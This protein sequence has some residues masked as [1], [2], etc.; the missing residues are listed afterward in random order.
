MP[1]GLLEVFVKVNPVWDGVKLRVRTSLQ[2]EVDAIDSIRVCIKHCMRWCDFS[3]TRWTKVGESGRLFLKS[4][5]IGIDGISEI[6]RKNDS[7]SRWHLAA[8]FKKAT[9]SVRLYLAVAALSGRATETM[10]LEL[11]EDDRFLLYHDRLWDGLQDELQ[12]LTR[13][14]DHFWKSIGDSIHVAPHDLK[15]HVLNC[16]VV[17]TGFVDGRLAATLSGTLDILS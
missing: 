15:S 10:L 11:M 13:A 14:P 4:V 16:S 17:S 1:P 8:S 9:L 6:A 2:A 3:E 5:L 7:V 12:Y